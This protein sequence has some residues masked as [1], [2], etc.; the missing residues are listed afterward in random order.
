MQQI[1]VEL[2]N[3]RQPWVVLSIPERESFVGTLAGALAALQAQGVEVLAYGVNDPDTDHRAPYDFFC[4]YQV[5]DAGLQRMFEAGIAASGW[6]DYFEQVNVS[7]AA[8]TPAGTLMKNVLLEPAK[9]QGKPVAA[10]WS[11]DKQSTT[12]DGHSMSYVDTGSGTPVVMIHGDV[13]SSFLWH[14]VIPHVAENHRAIAVDLIG[15]GDSDKLSP[16]GSGTYSFDVHARYLDGLLEALDL[17]EDVIL[18]GH[19]WGANLAFDWAIKH[20]ARVRGIAFAEA[21]LPPFEWSDWPVLVRQ[22][23]EY[24]RTEQGGKDV[25]ENNFFLGVARDNLA[26]V[27]PPAEWAEI[28]RP[29][30]N[31]GEDRRPML[32]WPRS[33][34]FGDDDTPVRRTLE[35]QADW[36]AQSPIPK[37]HLAGVPGGIEALGGRRRETIA[38]FPNLTVAD[39]TGL[40]WTP[41]DD[42]HG[43]GEG[44]AAWLATVVPG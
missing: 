12:V 4:V 17:G 18:V 11:Y 13:M 3:Y 20:E 42:P 39:V 9:R 30:A 41:L 2:Y 44:L 24:M 34:P 6:Y 32:D 7:G 40:H 21:L 29:Y 14:E 31:P 19:D 8:A 22:P 43:T 35:A 15:A 25:L 10:T 1:F 27:M 36:L 37:L 38:T 26:R 28:V 33:V 23:F 16:S 5:P